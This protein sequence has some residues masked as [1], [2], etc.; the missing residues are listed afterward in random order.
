P[1]KIE[2]TL[3]V[4]GQAAIVAR[5]DRHDAEAR[6]QP[7]RIDDDRL[8]LLWFLVFGLVL[9]LVLRL[10]LVVLRLLVSLL[11]LV[12]QFIVGKE[13]RAQTGTQGDIE[14]LGLLVEEWLRLP[15][16]PGTSDERA[17]VPVGEE[18]EELAVR[19]ERRAV[20]TVAVRRHVRRR[21][22]L[23]RVEFDLCE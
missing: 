9:L 22:G 17:E 14:D 6:S 1:G 23:D 12:V 15:A 10:L 20:T 19:A 4:G 8:L 5:R 18:V 16:A 3:A 21:A 13:G 2:E 11:F 7:V